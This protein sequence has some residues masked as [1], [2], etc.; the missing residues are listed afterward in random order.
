M[1]HASNHSAFSL[2]G[3]I[4]CDVSGKGF[5]AMS[6]CWEN[7]WLGRSPLRDWRERSSDH[8]RQTA[9]WFDK[10]YQGAT[11][12]G[13]IISR[14]KQDGLLFTDKCQRNEKIITDRVIFNCN[15]N[16]GTT[17]FA[18]IDK[19]FK[20]AKEVYKTIIYICWCLRDFH[21]VRQG[22]WTEENKLYQTLRSK[23]LR[24]DIWWT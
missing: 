18:V 10:G 15:L 16:R 21:I 11:T 24:S 1:E 2:Q 3:S 9:I 20:I 6:S 8:T 4:Y 22:L 12:F 5:I 17:F 19:R 13:W 7:W 23:I 14:K